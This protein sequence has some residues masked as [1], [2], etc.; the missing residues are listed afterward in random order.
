V[1]PST[2]KAFVKEQIES[3]N[4]E[5]DQEIQKKFSVYLGKRTKINR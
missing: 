5:F 4:G 2:L 3:G 1:H